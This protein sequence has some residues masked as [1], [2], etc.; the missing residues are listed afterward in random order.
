MFDLIREIAEPPCV[1]LSSKHDF[2]WIRSIHHW[3][4]HPGIRWTLYFVRQ[5]DPT[6]SKALVRAVLR[7]CEKCQSIDPWPT[8]W[9]KGKWDV[10]NTWFQVWMD[11]TYYQGRYYLSLTDCGAIQFF[12]WRHLR[13]DAA[14]VINHLD[15]LFCKCWHTSWDTHW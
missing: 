8:C 12:I 3:N 9:P 7:N 6:I 11:I 14:S 15:G 4:G 10:C 5:V 2:D 1:V 13:Q